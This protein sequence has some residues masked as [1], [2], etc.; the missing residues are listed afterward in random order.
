M[1][2]ARTSFS[3]NKGSR[4]LVCS[5][6]LSLAMDSC[7]AFIW[8]LNSFPA[9]RLPLKASIFEVESSR[10]M[11]GPSRL[12]VRR[13]WRGEER[14]Y[15]NYRRGDSQETRTLPRLPTVICSIDTMESSQPTKSTTVTVSK[16][17]PCLIILGRHFISCRLRSD[18]SQTCFENRCRRRQSMEQVL[19]D[20]AGGSRGGS[21]RMQ[22]H[23]RPSHAGLVGQSRNRP[24]HRLRFS[25]C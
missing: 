17:K 6:H 5:E 16:T 19:P 7:S 3:A 18:E 13:W 4:E 12:N 15:R 22:T 1:A 11:M 10:S 25:A 20:G 8:L 2:E 14:K 23:N 24:L 9:P 21:H